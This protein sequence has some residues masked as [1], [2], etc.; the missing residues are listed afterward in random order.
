MP[1]VTKVEIDAGECISC[2]A[3]VAECEAVFEMGE[4]TAVVKPEAQDPE[5]CKANTAGI[6]AAVEACPSEAIKIEKT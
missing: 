1:E 4:D 6:L 3:C 2:E 5:F